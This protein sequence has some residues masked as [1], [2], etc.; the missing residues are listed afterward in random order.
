MNYA[1]EIRGLTKKFHTGSF[2]R[3]KQTIALN[4]V[5]LQVKSGELLVLVGQ[6]G[7]GKTTLLKI[8]CGLILPT[9]GEVC[10]N[11]E[12]HSE[13]HSR[14]RKH[15]AFV[16]GEERSFYW[17]LTGR[18]NL[19]FFGCLSGLNKKTIQERINELTE[20]LD[21]N[22]ELNKEFRCFSSGAKQRLSLARALLHNPSII[23]MDEPMRSLDPLAHKKLHTFIKNILVK[24][25]GKTLFITT[26]NL[27]EA[28]ELA[29]RLAL[30]DKGQIKECAT[31]LELKTKFNSRPLSELFIQ[32]LQDNRDGNS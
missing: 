25:E 22:E 24:K 21:L 10:I 2:F 4:N 16:S 18:Q 8:L 14:F 3:R 7:A 13:Q 29:D 30:I 27:S 11:S 32:L 12:E 6:N 19:D 5:D 26:H 31:P 20:F 15:I 9:S 28:E 17:R 23:F 1:I